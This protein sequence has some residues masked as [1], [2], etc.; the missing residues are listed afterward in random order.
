[1]CLCE[2]EHEKEQKQE[3]KFIAMKK[4]IKGYLAKLRL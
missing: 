4:N 3:Q 1:V 2:Q